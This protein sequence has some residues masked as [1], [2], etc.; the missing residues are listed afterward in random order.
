M[1]VFFR[2]GQI[3]QICGEYLL[4]QEHK[5]IYWKHKNIV[6]NMGL[7][8]KRNTSE[9]NRPTNDDS[10]NLMTIWKCLLWQGKARKC[11]DN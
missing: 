9:T 1:L 6:Q 3:N 4:N 7:I 10:L 5:L 2:E 8:Q 11:S